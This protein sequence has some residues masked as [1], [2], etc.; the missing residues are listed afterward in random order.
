MNLTGSAGAFPGENPNI[1][2]GMSNEEGKRKSKAV[3]ACNSLDIGYSSFQKSQLIYLLLLTI[4][5]PILSS[6]QQ[7]NN[8]EHWLLD[9]LLITDH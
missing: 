3:V 4:Q 1:Q 2:Q 9:C 7:K 5:I 8:H 6:Y